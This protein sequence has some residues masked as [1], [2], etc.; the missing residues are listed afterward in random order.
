M[1]DQIL[2]NTKVHHFTENDLPCL[3]HYAPKAGGSHFTVT[4]AADLFLHGA[5][6]LFL[7]A[8]PM[9]K[10]N[11]FQQIAGMESQTAV[12]ANTDQLNKDAKALIIESGNEQRC[13]EAIRVLPDINERVVLIKNIEVFSNG[14][15]NACLKLPKL[16]LSGDLDRCSAKKHI[17]EK[18]WKTIVLFTKPQIPLPFD[19]PVLEKHLGYLWTGEMNGF[20]SILKND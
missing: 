14:L 6:V 1:A 17:S 18:Q 12:V 7:S 8:Y 2:F 19:P 15:F 13:L 16:I 4:L 5:K 9:A 3:I 20:V 11:F 10:D